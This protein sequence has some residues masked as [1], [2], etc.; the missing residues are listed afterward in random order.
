MGTRIYEEERLIL[1]TQEALAKAMDR[2]DLRR[3]D[4]ALAMGV[5]RAALTHELNDGSNM[6]LTRVAAIAHAAGYRIVPKLEKLVA[7]E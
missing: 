3:S 4:I 2:S 7:G 5:N 1:Y 6:T